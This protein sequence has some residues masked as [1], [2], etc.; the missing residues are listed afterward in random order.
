[1]ADDDD[2]GRR[3]ER[4]AHFRFAV[5]GPLLAAPPPKGELQQAL[6][7]L[8][9]RKWR[10]PI[11]KEPATWAPSTIER[12]YYR[13]LH[14]RTD[15]VR[16]LQRKLRK[17]LGRTIALSEPLQAKLVAQYQ[18][19]KSWS[20]QL[21]ADN[22]AVLAAED[23]ALARAP[24]YSTVRRF[25]R[26]HGLDRRRLLGPRGSPGAKR[27]EERLER[28]E[29]RS[30][31]AEYVNGL[32]HL[33][34][35]LGSRSVPVPSGRLV[36]PVLLGVL[37]DRSR[38]CCHAQWYLDEDSESLIHGLSQAFQKRR[39]PRSL[40]S[41]NGGPMEAGETRQGLARLG[42][43]HD[44]TLPYSPY[45]NA[46]Q[47]VFWAQV[48][49]RL[50]KMLEGVTDL[51]LAQLNEATQ[52]WVE[53]EYQ[54]KV[55]DE[56][57]QTPLARYLAGPDVGR[58]CPGSEELRRAFLAEVQRTQRRSDGTVS[59]EGVRFEVPNRYRT[60]HRVSIRYAG[61][62]L[63]RVY[64]LDP[65]TGAILC[66]LYP[67]DKERNADGQRRRIEPPAIAEAPPPTGMAP[68]LRK[69]LAD[70][71]ATGLPPAY[72]PKHEPEEEK[73]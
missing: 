64:L 24:S 56:T 73:P 40:L 30:Y 10:H 51:T 27:A 6:E 2:G 17:D 33:D 48:E 9:A 25:L 68:L 43:V 58:P 69:L 7:E 32:W 8:A 5:I 29:V 4:W 26:A 12:W 72:L 1:M 39:L 46:K 49:G 15:P 62:D 59:V 28:R 54:R 63:G 11:T 52:A 47:E 55:H 45:Q 60:L 57:H 53:M 67:V 71:A 44:N 18:A 16:V 35:H 66:P 34:F 20:A 22:L 65:H 50:L 31:E 3:H 19:H 61:W 38:L 14:E 37:D 21:H 42:I 13:A 23:S 41:D 70:Y 36:R